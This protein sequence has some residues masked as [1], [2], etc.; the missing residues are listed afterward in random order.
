MGMVWRVRMIEW[1]TSAVT[2]KG[3]VVVV[4]VAVVIV[5]DRGGCGLAGSRTRCRLKPWIT[6]NKVDRQST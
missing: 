6:Y 5:D 1:T 2:G 4:V 3:T